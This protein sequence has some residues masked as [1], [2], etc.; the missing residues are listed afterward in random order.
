M[1]VGEM[2]SH[3]FEKFYIS[4]ETLFFILPHYPHLPA[5]YITTFT[6]IARY[7]LQRASVGIKLMFLRNSQCFDEYLK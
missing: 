1:G 3:S 7:A 5:T 4:K 2:L 6:H